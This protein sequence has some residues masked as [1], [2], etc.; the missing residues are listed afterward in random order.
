M[1]QVMYEQRKVFLVVIKYIGT[2]I[3]KLLSLF[4]TLFFTIT[5][6]C[7]SMTKNTQHMKR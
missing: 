3:T 5:T 7:I 2:I 6:A 4:C 1:L